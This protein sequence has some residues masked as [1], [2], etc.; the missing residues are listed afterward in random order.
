MI[1]EQPI[2]NEPFVT[3]SFLTDSG[4][5]PADRMIRRLDAAILQQPTPYDGLSRGKLGQ[6]LYALTA[7]DYFQE[8]AYT[9]TGFRLLQ[10]V[11]SNLGTAAGSVQRTTSIARGLSGLGLVLNA[12]EQADKIDRSFTDALHQ[13]LIAQLVP[14]CLREIAA[15]NVDPL[16][17]AP[18]AV[19]YLAKIARHQESAR[20]ALY[21]IVDAFRAVAETDPRGLKLSNQ[22]YD[23][24]RQ[25]NLGLAHGLCG[26]V[27]VLLE[28]AQVVP[29]A[30]GLPDLI[31]G[32]VDYIVAQRAPVAD[33]T[34]TYQFPRLVADGAPDYSVAS[35]TAM[36][37]CYSDL[38]M[39]F[40][41]FKAARV[42]NEPA[43]QT[44]AN[45]LVISTLARRSYATTHIDE[46]MFCHGA[47]SMAWLFKKCY[48]QYPNPAYRPGI[49]WWTQ[50]TVRLLE[51]ELA[52]GTQP[53][54]PELLNGWNGA[55]L[56]LM[57]VTSHVPVAWDRVFFLA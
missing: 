55:S 23:Q 1:S 6:A 35:T 8:G 53:Q 47:S 4:N 25:T 42:L 29:S 50:E 40:M 44:L 34:E 51:Q 20:E 27:L 9:E 3:E 13:K 5:S 16:H 22:R 36:G 52:S 30:P 38:S 37:W 18:G 2:L 10:T 28:V 56:V 12:I 48:D 46:A 21:P 26:I 54:A 24:T 49:D 15:R 39:A 45:E 19:Y 7:G 33:P 57:S 17:S 31:R 43:W 32:L 14:Q 11:I 41:L